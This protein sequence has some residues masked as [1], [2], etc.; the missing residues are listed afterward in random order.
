[1]STKTKV[2]RVQELRRSSAAS[3]H[4]NKKAYRRSR[5]HAGRGWV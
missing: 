2:Q 4:R 5:K 3:P 1:M